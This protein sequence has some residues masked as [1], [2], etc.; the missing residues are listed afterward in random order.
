VLNFQVDVAVIESAAAADDG[1]PTFQTVDRVQLKASF[2]MPTGVPA[3]IPSVLLLHG[4]GEDRHVWQ[5][6]KRQL[7]NQGYAVMSLDLRGHG[8][9][10]TRNGTPLQASESWRATSLEF[11]QELDPALDWLK[12]QPRLEPRKIVVIGYD[13][14]A[15][16]ALLASGQFPEVRTVIAVKPNLSESLAL[17]GSAQ[18]F[19][20]RSALIIVPEAAEGDR[21]KPYVTAPVEVRVANSAGGTPQWFSQQTVID[22]TIQWLK[23][24]Y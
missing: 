12:E 21:L 3:P 5:G 9:S 11:P 18:D 4:F 17:A 16:L 13:V 22:A 20:P 15:N 24:T 7:L 8:Q 6:F 19:H 1:G 23:Q 10:T 2:E 14:G